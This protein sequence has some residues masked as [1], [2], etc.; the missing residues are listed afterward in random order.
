M[1]A[2][3]TVRRLFVHI[4]S[5]FVLRHKVCALKRGDLEFPSDYQGVLWATMDAGNGWKQA[6]G[7]ELKAAGD[8]VDGD[9]VMLS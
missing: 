7:R 2:Q 5:Y 1:Q 8:E 6:L 4:R 3:L 9:K